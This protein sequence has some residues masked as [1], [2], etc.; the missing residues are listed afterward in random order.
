MLF[1]IKYKLR[2]LLKP[3]ELYGLTHLLLTY[4]VQDIAVGSQNVHP[5]VKC[6]SFPTTE[7]GW[8]QLQPER[9]E[10]TA[11]HVLSRHRRKAGTLR[12][13]VTTGAKAL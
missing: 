7:Q 6:R 10:A 9:G 5:V 8:L 11:A 2:S 4:L 12:W 1:L 3:K 13:T